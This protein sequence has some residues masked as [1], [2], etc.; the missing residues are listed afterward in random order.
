MMR[1]F[2]ITKSFDYVDFRCA[3]AVALLACSVFSVIYSFVPAIEH[4]LVLVSRICAVLFVSGALLS[5][6]LYW[7]NQWRRA[8]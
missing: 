5:M 7:R 8:E 3:L 2:K 4:S 1:E 6:C